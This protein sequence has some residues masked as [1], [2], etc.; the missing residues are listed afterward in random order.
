M[1]ELEERRIELVRK[2]MSIAASDLAAGQALAI[3]PQSALWIHVAFHA[4]QSVE[5]MLKAYLVLQD[6]D[7]PFSHNI[8]QILELCAQHGGAG[9]AREVDDAR[10]LTPFAVQSRYPFEQDELQRS[11]IEELLG[12]A[13]R[14]GQIV[15]AVIEQ[16]IDARNGE[17]IKEL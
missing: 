16:E 17:T 3:S 1:N 6:I 10:R 13:S 9:W 14:V 12:I 2:W 5:K 8:G 7:P 11:E 4:Q 15:G